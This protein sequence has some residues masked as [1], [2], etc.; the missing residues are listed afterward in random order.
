MQRIT[1]DA[2]SHP[3]ELL[4]TL[5]SKVAL[6]R[7]H[8]PPSVSSLFAIPRAGTD[9][10]LQWWSEL[11]G[12]P[13][14]YHSLDAG[15]QQALLARYL[16]R[17]QA[18]VQLADELQARDR[19][20]EANSLRTLVGAPSLNNLYSLNDEPVVIR[21]GMAQPVTPAIPSTLSV[22]SLASPASRRWWLRI[23]VLLLLLPLLLI[24]L[25]L[26]WAWRG[27]VWNVFN[28]VPMGNYSCTQGVPA[29]DFAVVLDTSG[30][31]NLNIDTSSE[32][33]AW[34]YHVGGALPADNPRKARVLA[35]PTRLT[36]AKQAFGAML[37]QL[38]PD[39]DTRLITFQGCEGTV[40][41]GVFQRDA[42][43]QLLAGVGKLSA[44]GG[45]PLVASLIKAASLVDGRFK[46]AL[47]VM[48]V[49]GED[50]CG[51]NA[52]EVSARIA[53]QQPRLRMNV[54]NIS[55]SK[56]SNC[57]AENTGGRVYAAREAGEV[58]RMLREAMEEVA[59][60]PACTEKKIP[61]E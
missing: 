53:R 49:D 52:C 54:V 43:Q 4:N 48:F 33:E 61:G 27:S 6:L 10:T 35:E 60:A 1:I 8:F 19:A 41:Q 58:Q 7:R 57:I 26:L 20:D 37:G 13:L 47:V 32:D 56:L 21:W 42:R 2:T 46:D 11:G 39:I 59:A 24:L 3:A 30:S 51:Q 34:M 16:Q 18:I 44:D 29:P 36:V 17:Q 23:P 28:T 12:Q 25:W 5:E 15:A 22:S 14:P 9:G 31:M 55:D 50:G 38:H 40:D 45:T